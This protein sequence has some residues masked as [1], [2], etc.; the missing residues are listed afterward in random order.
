VLLVLVPTVALAF[1]S[2][3]ARLDKRHG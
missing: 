2:L 3:A 1:G